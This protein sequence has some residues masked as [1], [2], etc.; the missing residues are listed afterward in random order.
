MKKI[1]SGAAAICA[2]AI[3]GNA[4]AHIGIA[5]EN[6]FALGEGTREYLEGKSATLGVQLPHDCSNANG[7]HFPTTDVVVIFPNAENL[8]SNFITTR[9]DSVYTANAMMGI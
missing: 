7:D 3:A 1:I 6:V 2:M 8:S 5:R 4:V 9:G